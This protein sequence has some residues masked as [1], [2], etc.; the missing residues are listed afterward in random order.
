MPFDVGII[1]VSDRASTGEREDQCIPVFRA[2]LDAARFE[3]G[4]AVIVSDDPGEIKDALEQ[5]IDHG[6]SLI[7]TSGGTGCA[8][9]DNTPEVTIR[10]LE[11]P[12]PGLDQAIRNY[13]AGKSRNAAFSRAYS[14]VAG[15]SFIVNLPGSPKAVGEIL[16]FISPIIEH[17]L[18]LIAG[19][20]KDCRDEDQS[21]AKP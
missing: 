18:K 2:V 14:G 17:P 4:E 9:R 13:S 19:Q 20:L 15:R 12:T 3:I 1:I 21:D 8:P 5:M 10:L 11:K 6:Y 7:F 16:E